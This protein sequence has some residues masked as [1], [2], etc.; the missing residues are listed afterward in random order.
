[1]PL[2]GIMEYPLCWPEDW[3]VTPDADRRTGV[4][5]GSLWGQFVRLEFITRKFNTEKFVISCNVPPHM[6]RQD[7]CNRLSEPGVAVYFGLNGFVFTLACDTHNDVKYN[8]GELTAILEAIDKTHNHGCKELT[9]RLLSGFVYREP[10][11]R[12]WHTAPPSVNPENMHWYELIGV[13]PESHP[14]V[15]EAAFKA[16]VKEVRPDL[17]GNEVYGRALLRAIKIARAGYAN[18]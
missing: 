3:K 13:H 18:R 14:D 8:L 1:M 4:M 16:K 2:D 10:E 15:I 9:S 7:K 5:L 6:R 12:S 17:P 11:T